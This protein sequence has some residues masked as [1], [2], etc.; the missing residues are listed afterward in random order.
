MI[1]YMTFKRDLKE[2]IRSFRDEASTSKEING[3]IEQLDNLLQDILI[4]NAQNNG[5]TSRYNGDDSCMRI[6]KNLKILR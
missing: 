5:L 4:L 6:H 2:I 1:S 3:I